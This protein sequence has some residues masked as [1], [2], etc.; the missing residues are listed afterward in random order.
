MEQVHEK[1]KRKVE[2]RREWSGEARRVPTLA[3]RVG[4]WV[5]AR[6]EQR[7]RH[8]E[9]VPIGARAR[10]QKLESAELAWG[11]PA[12]RKLSAACLHARS[13]ASVGVGRTTRHE[14]PARC[15]GML[16]RRCLTKSCRRRIQLVTRAARGSY[17]WWLSRWRPC[18]RARARISRSNGLVARSQPS[19]SSWPLTPL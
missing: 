16:C 6:A 10:R 14:G 8:E 18:R 19:Q 2:G 9:R 1:V 13:G 11:Q 4:E 5:C 15:T 3:W 17:W 12:G 7:K